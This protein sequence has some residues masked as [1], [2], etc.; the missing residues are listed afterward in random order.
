[1]SRFKELISIVFNDLETA[2][3]IKNKIIAE[4]KSQQNL[5]NDFLKPLI[6]PKTTD[7]TNH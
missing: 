4:P 5:N 3:V 2:G 1:M 6:I 7:K